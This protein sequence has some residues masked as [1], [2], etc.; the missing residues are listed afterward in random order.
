MPNKK[1][2]ALTAVT[3]PIDQTFNG[4][5]FVQGGV[6]KKV[7]P[8]D[9]LGIYRTKISIPS[10]QVL[11]LGTIPV[12]AIPSPGVGFAIQII[13]MTGHNIFNS[14]AYS[15]GSNFVAITDTATRP[16]FSF[17]FLPQMTVDAIEFGVL[18][19]FTGVTST[20]I[21]ED[22]AVYLKSFTGIDY[23]LGDSDIEVYLTWELIAV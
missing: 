11:T 19:D 10:A 6:T 3:T 13:K 14:V 7:S 4:I 23:T 17:A 18:Q 12:L 9:L 8:Q 1:I 21:I 22:K 16:Q 15:G 20:Q 2:T 5:P